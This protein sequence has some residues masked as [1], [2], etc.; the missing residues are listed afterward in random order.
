MK[1]Y[2]ACSCRDPQTKKLLG[3][4]CPDLAKKGHGGWYARYEAPRSANGKRR[5][6]RVGPFSTETEC[7]KAVAKVLGTAA[8][9]KAQDERNTTFGEYLERRYAWRVSE[10]ETGEGLARTTLDAERETIDLYAKPGLGHIKVVDLTDEHFR[11][12]YADMRKINRPEEHTEKTELL[13]RLLEA[14]FSRDGKRRHSRPIGESRIRR[15]H[16]VLH[17]AL[18]DAVKLSKIR[19]DNPT[20]GVWR[21]KGGKR[22]AGRKKPLLWTA[23]RVEQWQKTGVVPTRV[24]VW[25]AD[26]TGNFLDFAEAS[27]ERLYPAFHLD[28]YYGPRR[29]ELVAAEEQHFSLERARLHILQSQAADELDDTKSEAG[30]RQVPLDAETVRVHRAW[31]KRK[32][33]ERLQWGELYQD[34]GRL[35]CYEDG[36]ELKPEYLSSRFGILIE[37]HGNIRARRAEGWSVERIA[38]KYRTAEAA[39]EV[40][41]LMPLPPIRFH[42]LRHGAATMLLAAGVPIKFVSEILGHASVSFTMDVYAVVAEEMAADATARIAAFIPRQNR[43]AAVGA[44]NVPSGR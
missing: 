5:Q 25:T 11:E 28:A 4:K 37:R 44:S 36:Q 30:W 26:Q 29:G 18:T 9:P 33:E 38:R 20:D 3:K 35:Y 23:E 6:P 17:G 40:A 31:H 27:Q 8:S 21:S 39:V 1:P 41:L 34:S 24:M 22:K 7:K 43:L 42:D 10:A 2:R 32:I 13:R 12:L 16:A 15:V 19:A 14:R